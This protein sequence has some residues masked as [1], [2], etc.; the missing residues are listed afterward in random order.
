MVAG[1]GGVGRRKI[2]TLLEA[3]PE[4]LL[5][6]DPSPPD[7]RL[8]ELLKHPALRFEQR[9]FEESDLDGLFLAVAATPHRETNA[10]IGRLCRERGILCNV[11]DAPDEGDFIVPAQTCCGDLRVAVSTSGHSPALARRIKQDLQEYLGLRYKPIVTLM[12]RLRPLVLDLGRPTPENTDLFHTLVESPLI[13]ALQAKDMVRAR[14]VLLE[15]LPPEL[16]QTID[17]V[18]HELS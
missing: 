18:L 12:G 11:V 10:R 14:M 4:E 17:E 3:A 15:I 8:R 1:A 16:H 7:A 13:D 5:I 2:G 6:I 9:Y